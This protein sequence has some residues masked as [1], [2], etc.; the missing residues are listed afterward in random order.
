MRT[1][2]LFSGVGAW[3]SA[4]KRLGIE[5]DL[6][7]YSEIDKYAS[8]SF[9]L[10][11]GVSED[12]NLGDITKIDETQLPEDIDL[13]TYSPPCQTFSVAGLR[14][15]TEDPRGI[16]FFD[17]LRLIK[18][19]KP[20]YAVMENV[21]NLTGKQFKATFSGMLESLEEAG[22]SNYWKVL[23]AVDY[24]VPQNRERVFIVSIRKD[25]DKGYAFPKPVKLEKRLKDILEQSVP[26]KYYL[27]QKMIDYFI[28]H[29]EKCKEKGWGHSWKPK[30]ADDVANTLRTNGSLNTTDNTI[31]CPSADVA[32]CITARSW[33]CGLDDNYI[34]HVQDTER[35]IQ[36]DGN[37][38]PNS[39]N[40]QAGRVYSPEGISPALD[41]C[42]GGNRMPK[43]VEK[44][45]MIGAS[46]GRNPENPSDRTTG[47]PTEQRLEINEKGVSNTL[48]SVGKDNYV[49]EI[50]QYPRGNNHGGSKGGDVC[51]SITSSKFEY[52]NVLFENSGLRIRR[53]MPV[54]CLRLMGFTDDE[55]QRLDG[56]LSDTQL[57]KIAGNSIVVDVLVAIF[58]N[59][60]FLSDDLIVE[61]DLF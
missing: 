33:K 12:L 34:A 18:Y 8:K 43:I 31:V 61:R 5:I 36:I 38:Y 60:F 42:T 19:C 40:P 22:Y 2:S 32:N 44:N 17:A 24:G 16:L 49:V 25:L 20:K 46:R 47:A 53:L 45:F 21:K 58:Q 39:G 6:V 37:L 15:G 10:V 28:A 35:I 54:E 59:L 4:L 11:H 55:F 56:Q 29:N 14:K 30:V 57:Y 50:M 41:T 26:E 48:T 52:N 23:N 13:V 7:G 27:S 1:L 3:E 51:P 9:S